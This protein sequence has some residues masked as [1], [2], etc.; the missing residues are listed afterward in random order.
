MPRIIPLFLLILFSVKSFSQIPVIRSG[1]EN[2]D[3]Y[4]ES[5]EKLYKSYYSIVAESNDFIKGTEYLPY[6][7]RSKT[8]PLLF[9]GKSFITDLFMDR[10]Y[11]RTNLQYDTYREG[12][13]YTDT[14]KM[15]N[16]QYPKINLAKEAVDSFTFMSDIGIMKFK[17]LRFP[18]NGGSTMKNGFY[19]IV[20]EGP[21]RFM[22]RHISV[23][24]RRDALNEYDY[25]PENYILGGDSWIRVKNSRELFSIFGNQSESIKDFIRNESIRIRKMYKNDIV[26]VLRYYDASL[27]RKPSAE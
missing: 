2:N 11:F 18:D 20:Y 3:P 16:A 23:L 6:D 25:S 21:S 4:G 15:I 17:N 24:Y 14:S 8:T 1:Q 9:S 27:K 22:I 19:E 5:K 26:R 10:R 12:L 13:I 7:Y